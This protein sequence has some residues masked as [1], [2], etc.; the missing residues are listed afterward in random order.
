VQDRDLMRALIVEF[1]GP[2]ALVFAG[3]GAIISTGLVPG[4]GEFGGDL[5]AVALAHGLAIG[6]IIT[7]AGHISGGHLNPAVTAGFW[8]TRRI[9]TEKAVAYIIAQL[10]GGL[11]GAVCLVFTFRDIDR[12]RV[13]LG[14]P[15]IGANLEWY[16]ALVME[17]ILTFFLV[18]VIF[19]A[20]VDGR[21]TRYIPGLAIGLTISMDIMAGGAVSGAAMNPARYLGPAI[22]QWGDTEWADFWIWFVGPV[23]GAAIAAFLYND[24]LMGAVRPTV[25]TR[26]AATRTAQPPTRPVDSTP[27]V[28]GDAERGTL[29]EAPPA[30]PSPRSQRR[31][32][33]R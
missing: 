6:L 24:V 14:V 1:I 17:T 25:P 29:V 26:G 20:A 19:G 30:Q 9:T 33:R 12:N 23:A 2:F 18:F 13:N 32:Q 15:A 4:T 21:A 7:A 16:N 3:V 11:A 28:T 8:L 10:L 27:D 31:R 5:V 22:V